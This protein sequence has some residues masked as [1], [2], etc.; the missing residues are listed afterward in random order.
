[1]PSPSAPAWNVSCN[2]VSGGSSIPLTHIERFEWKSMVNGGYIIKGRA[3]DPYFNI[4]DKVVEGSGGF[5]K[6]GR[7]PDP[8]NLLLATFKLSWATD[9]IIETP[10]CVA[11]VSEMHA[12]GDASMSGSF[13]FIA[14][15]PVS[16]FVNSGD[17]SGA[18][19]RGKIGG[20]DGV[21]AQVLRDYV[22]KKIGEY[23]IEVKVDD[24][25]DEENTYWMMRQDPK[26]FIVSLLDWSS[27]F[28]KHKTSWIVSNGYEKD[29]IIIKVSESHTPDL[30]Y[31]QSIPNDSG[32]FVLSSGFGAS[33]TIIKWEIL[34]DNFLS[35]LNL[36]LITSGLST[37]S[38][39]YL[40][41]VADTDGTKVYVEDSNTENK[42]NVNVT[43]KQSFTKPESAKGTETGTG[44]LRPPTKR[45]WTHIASVPEIYS[46][47]D[48]GEKY[49]NYIDGRARQAYIEMLNMLLR[50]RLT[51]RGQPR[52]VFSDDLAR[53]KITVR[54]HKVNPGAGGS[55][56]RFIDGDWM[57]YGWHHIL[58][59]ETGTWTTDVYLSRLDWDAA[60]LKG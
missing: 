44:K 32:D 2:L 54:W 6:T 40:D 16:Y 50:I 33:P 7:S 11:L 37:V 10:M 20:D 31:P 8:K 48:I 23:D 15:D 22:P 35:A 56:P 13:E 52:L 41:K 36:K 3:A 59:T 55:E 51:V 1:M 19:Y 27:S 18:A 57:L 24:T 4:L 28:T 12:R 34:A 29:K 53:S 45:G 9:P 43:Q 26:T 25:T 58:V 49:S 21:I 47:N 60:A 17:C 30:G 46:G 39:E 14:V 42:Q 5:L 38:G